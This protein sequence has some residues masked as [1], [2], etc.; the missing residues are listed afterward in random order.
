M[1]IPRFHHYPPLQSI[2]EAKH[3]QQKPY[4]KKIFLCQKR[5]PGLF[6]QIFSFFSAQRKSDILNCPYR[7]WNWPC[8]PGMD[9][10]FL[11]V[12][13]QLALLSEGSQNV[14]FIVWNL[15]NLALPKNSFHSKKG[16]IIAT[17]PPGSASY[18][19]PQS[20]LP[21]VRLE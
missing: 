7:A 6:S 4:C 1:D 20:C 13:T 5:L 2:K 8:I 11:A 3:T 9:L 17:G 14:W 16:I 12:V 18:H 19:I 10:P 15:H 21:K